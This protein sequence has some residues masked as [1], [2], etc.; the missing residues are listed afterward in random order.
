MLLNYLKLAIKVLGRNKMYTAITLFGISFTLMVLMIILA[1][2][3]SELGANTPMSKAD[4]M[5]FVDHMEMWKPFYDTAWAVDSSMVGDLMVYDTTD[6]TTEESGKAIS[7]GSMSL[8]LVEEHLADVE[9]MERR[10][11]LFDREYTVF[12]EGRKFQLTGILTDYEYWNIFDFNFLAGESF[13]LEQV[14]EAASVAVISSSTAED[15][16]G[17]IQQSIGQSIP[18]SGREHEILGVVEKG[19]SSSH[20]INADIY[21]PYTTTEPSILSETG[22]SGPFTAVYLAPSVSQRTAMQEA[23]DF[24]G[25]QIP[26]PPPDY[27]GAFVLDN[28]KVFPFT[29]EEMYA[30]SLFHEDEIDTNKKY[31]RL[32]LVL[33]LGLFIL[34]PTL[35]LI[36]VNLT[37]MMERASEISVRKTYGA[38]R[39]QILGQF[40][41][42]NIIV[43]FIGGLI[44]LALSL[45]IINLI[46]SSGAMP[47]TTLAFNGRVFFYSFLMCLLLGILSGLLPAWRIS[48]QQ[49]ADGLRQ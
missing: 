38:S 34:I 24:K 4:R 44:G 19:R 8:R 31:F 21:V 32:M 26:I 9:P 3:D 13:T 30:W 16:F 49:I 18:I 14:E 5:I 12:N 27:P 46:N 22:N 47:N 40:L 36:N 45:L 39:Q 17:G 2:Y 20:Y 41:F 48:K 29:Q 1:L 42:E 10:S 37:R 15:Y 28:I 11:I 6:F 33:S 23:L 43:T 35:N 7:S 25:R